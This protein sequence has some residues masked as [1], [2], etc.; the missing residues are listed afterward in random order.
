MKKLLLLLIFISSLK[1]FAQSEIQY[2]ETVPES[3]EKKYFEEKHEYNPLHVGDFWQYTSEEFGEYSVYNVSVQKDTLVNQVKYFFK[4]DGYFST[5][6]RNDTNKLSSYLLDIDDLD[7]DGN[8]NEELLLDSL[9]VPNFTEY[10]S[11]RYLP[12]LYPI[13]VPTTAFV[14]DSSWAIIFGDTVMTRRIQYVANFSTDIVADKFGVLFS[15][16][17]GPPRILNGAIINGITYG[18]IV[19]VNDEH[20]PVIPDKL[21]LSQ[22]YPNPF[23]PSTKIVYSLPNDGYVRL[24]VF[25]L[26]GMELRTLVNREQ[27]AGNYEIVFNG[28]GLASGIYIYVLK[29]NKKII[30]KKMLLLK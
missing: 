27:K 1:I 12:Q 23:N 9:E 25:N 5:W 11:Y 24:S 14:E 15:M 28:T 6:E 26:L 17:D 13:Y 30:S 8:S 19:S 21:I 3:F 10:I 4:S 18:L 2:I 7:K 22:N 16:A 29:N 20:F